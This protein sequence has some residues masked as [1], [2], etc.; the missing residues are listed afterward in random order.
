MVAW[1]LLKSITWC[2]LHEATSGKRSKLK[3]AN[4]PKK[5]ICPYRSSWTKD[6]RLG[7]RRGLWAI[8]GGQNHEPPSRQ[9]TLSRLLS[10]SMLVSSF[11]Q[12]T[13]YLHGS[14]IPAEVLTPAVVVEART[15]PRDRLSLL[16][17]DPSKSIEE[18]QQERKTAA[19]SACG[20][21][22]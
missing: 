15:L 9:K 22:R 5:R 3:S 11:C 4:Q 10:K 20:Q 12:T 2:K 19:L 18:V 7:A 16:A 13:K 1:L 17:F 8:E 14:S 21:R 6:C